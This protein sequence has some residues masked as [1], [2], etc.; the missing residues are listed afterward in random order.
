MKLK[1]NKRKKIF[2]T[3]IIII[4]TVA[5]VMFGFKAWNKDSQKI[6]FVTAKATRGQIIN[7]VTATGTIQAIKTVAV[8]TQ[9][10]GVISK[11]YADYN[12]HVTKGQLLAELDK[13]PLMLNLENSQASFENAKAEMTYQTSNY[14]RIKSLFEKKLVAQSDYD[15]ALYNYSKSQASLKSATSEYNKAKINLNYAT[16]Y[17]P[18]DGVVL[19]RAVDEGQTVA[20]SFSTPTLFSI[21]NDLT[22]MQ[23]EV[24]ID[25]AD[26][27][28]IKQQQ[29]VSFTVDAFPNLKFSGEVTQIR[30]NPVT[31]SNVVTY[32]VIVKA[33]NPDYK[34]MPGMTASIT[35]IVEE[36]SES[37]TIPR[38]A[39]RFSPDNS[40]LSA[41]INS[42][43]DKDKNDMQTKINSFLNAKDKSHARVWVKQ[44]NIIR[45]LLIEIGIEDDSKVNVLSGLKEGDDIVVSMN[46]NA[47][48]NSTSE[49]NESSP[50][51]PKGPGKK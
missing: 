33:P 49:S 19:E 35:I 36:S 48:G 30:L 29:K 9:V 32:T 10:S 51:M 1:M 24:S 46:N 12:S 17:S 5:V 31:K 11:I 26:I 43:D 27:G 37:L 6:T 14:N 2:I 38:K 34:L 16:I 45:P 44:G 23:V 41:Y 40:S 18:I 4:I 25:E 21:A 42:L 28:Q 20:A 15:L 22:Q 39:L 50:F 13:R 3:C 7:T 47:A 8:G